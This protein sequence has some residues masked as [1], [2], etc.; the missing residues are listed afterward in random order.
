[1][2]LDRSQTTRRGE[3][4]GEVGRADS[5]GIAARNAAETG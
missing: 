4:T 1:M 5:V 3:G 2:S